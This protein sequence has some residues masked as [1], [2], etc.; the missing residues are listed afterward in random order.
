MHISIIDKEIFNVLL[1]FDLQLSFLQYSFLQPTILSPTSCTTNTM[2]S[3][4][5]KRKAPINEG[6][7]KDSLAF[8]KK[9]RAANTKWENVDIDNMLVRLVEAKNEGKI[10]D[11]GFK[12]TI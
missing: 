1:A 5:L 4:P 8:T 2:S 12:N 6:L 9:G 7:S 3:N 10:G 11:N